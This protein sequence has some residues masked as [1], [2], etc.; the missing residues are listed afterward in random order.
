MNTLFRNINI[1]AAAILALVAQS[2]NRADDGTMQSGTRTITVEGTPT[3]TTIG[4]EGSDVSH[5]EWTDG[6]KVAYVTD[7]EGDTFRVADI[8]QNK[9]AAEI[10]TTA[11]NIY[12]IYP[13]GD[14]E[15]K[16]LGEVR[17]TLASEVVQVAGESFRGE[18]LPMMAQAAV[19]ATENIVDVTYECLASV[20]RFT[21]FGE[22]HEEELLQHLEISAA[23]SLAGYYTLN[24]DGAMSFTGVSTKIV[25]DYSGES[26]DVL[27]ASSH[28]IYVV[29]PNAM[30]TDVDVVV[31]T[32]TDKYSWLDGTMSL[33]APERRLYRVTLNLSTSAEA[34]PAAKNYYTPVLN[35]DEIT[36]DG[37]YL[38]AVAR[39]GKYYVT[40]NQ[41][42]NTS[43][44]YYVA[45]VE[46]AAGEEGILADQSTEPYTWSI[47][48]CDE[49][50]EFYSANILKQGSYGVLLITQGGTGMFSGED[51]YEGKAWYVSR[52]TMD[53]YDASA[54]MRRYWDIELD[55]EGTAVLRNKYDRGVDMFPCYK[56][57]P[58]H[59]YF[60]LCFEGGG[61]A[62]E[63]ITLLKLRK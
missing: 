23:E 21:I 42:T 45:G 55:G 34:P 63:D 3:R 33:T 1:V 25:V 10:A 41:F 13:V 16:S 39:N 58:E 48:K 43:N 5:L 51:G 27:L 20:L 9:F 4:Y 22:G 47:T 12:V 32:N 59:E 49:G 37:S 46:V 26:E 52:E 61:S 28:D 54:Q 7:V 53:G 30:F 62:K 2:C 14:N 31:S 57:C 6:D 35:P 40:D 50:Y 60:T 8:R 11:K 19:P 36:D 29:V 38:I 44:P 17:A 15:G 56:Y 24:A 18:M